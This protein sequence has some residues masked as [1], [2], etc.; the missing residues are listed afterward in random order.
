VVGV[1]AGSV[2]A[3]AVVAGL[4][5][6][7]LVGAGGDDDV[8]RST[9]PQGAA[10]PDDVALWT[11]MVG[12]AERIQVGSPESEA[13]GLDALGDSVSWPT[14]TKDRRTI[15]YLRADSDTGP[16]ELWAA[17]SGGEHPRRIIDDPD[18]TSVG[19]PSVN[20]AGTAVAVVC[21]ES[22]T[23]QG[24]PGIWI[25][26]VGGNLE[27]QLEQGETVG[28]PTWTA[29]GRSLVYW[30]QYT[31]PESNAV[32][33][34]LYAAAIDD[35]G[36]EPVRLTEGPVL[37]ELP[38]VTPDS[39]AVIFVRRTA[40]DGPR[41]LFIMALREEGATLARKAKARPMAASDQLGSGT[42]PT[43][44][45]AG[46]V[47]WFL[48]KQAVYEAAVDAA[49]VAQPVDGLAGVDKVSWSRR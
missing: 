23:D 43:L 31:D 3:L 29:D 7:R 13:V 4:V 16:D 33:S 15:L 18:C 11:V 35:D 38:V 8:D 34:N 5:V 9:L 10:L 32:G 2:L 42:Q 40:P 6:W 36:A 20:P 12:S 44:S 14:L 24:G 22:S 49:A 46:T 17:G 37:D 21:K 45:P 25:Y 41:G 39:S 28:N 27:H 30:R 26:S 19:R 47:L 48:N 1:V